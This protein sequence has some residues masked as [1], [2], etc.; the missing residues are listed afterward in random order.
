MDLGIIVVWIL[1]GLFFAG[2]L[3]ASI[4]LFLKRKNGKPSPFL[5]FLIGFIPFAVWSL[6]VYKVIYLD[7]GLLQAACRGDR[8]S[9][10]RLLGLGAN[11]EAQPETLTPL[12]CAQS[13]GHKEIVSLLVKAGARK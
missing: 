3:I 2:A 1:L 11:P 13:N 4:M 6:H 10:I 12:G 5:V 7:E 8:S 9:V